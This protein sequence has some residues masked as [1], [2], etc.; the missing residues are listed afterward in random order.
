MYCVHGGGGV[1]DAGFRGP[2]LEVCEKWNISDFAFQFHDF[3]IERTCDDVVYKEHT[4][5]GAH[6]IEQKLFICRAGEQEDYFFFIFFI[7]R[8]LSGMTAG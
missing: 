3:D 6:G 7:R 2:G 1:G 8:M 4:I 5:D